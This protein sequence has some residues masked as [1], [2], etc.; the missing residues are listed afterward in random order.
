MQNKETAEDEQNWKVAYKAESGRI[1]WDQNC[2]NKAFLF[3]LE[4]RKIIRNEG[5]SFCPKA[6]SQRPLNRRKYQI[7]I[8]LTGKGEL[9]LFSAAANQEGGMPPVPPSTTIKYGLRDHNFAYH[10]QPGV[11][12]YLYQDLLKVVA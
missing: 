9:G 4:G 12:Y 7:R 10:M 8:M 2:S 1:S 6:I 11:S 3:S 5:Q